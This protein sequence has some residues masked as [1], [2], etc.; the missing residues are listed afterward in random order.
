MQTVELVTGWEKFRLRLVTVAVVSGESEGE[1]GE[2]R[3]AR[4]LASPVNRV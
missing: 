2:V 3:L 1:P 4:W